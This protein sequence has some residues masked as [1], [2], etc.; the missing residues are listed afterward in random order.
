MVLE[1]RLITGEERMGASVVKLHLIRRSGL[2]ANSFPCQNAGRA[3]CCGGLGGFDGAASFLGE[4]P[5]D[6]LGGEG[7]GFVG[8]LG[9]EA[10]VAFLASGGGTYQQLT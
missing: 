5:G 2:I 7:G 10:G 8:S 3:G 9:K 6:G 1:S 4:T